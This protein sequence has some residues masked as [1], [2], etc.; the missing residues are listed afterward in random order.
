MNTTYV[1]YDKLGRIVLFGECDDSLVS[2]QSVPEGCKL[3][4]GVQGHWNTHYII[5]DLVIEKPPRPSKNHTFNYETKSWE[6]DLAYTLNQ[7]RST[8]NNLIAQ[9]DWTQLS[10]I[11]PETKALWE[12]YRQ[13]LR[14]ITDQEDP[15]NITW[16]TPP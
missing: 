3:I 9:S 5:N 1:I 2:L 8:R 4:K 10:D 16:P 12:P 13:A 14:N 11:P 6:P 15:F 7:I